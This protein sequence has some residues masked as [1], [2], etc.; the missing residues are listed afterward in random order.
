MEYAE[1]RA[2]NSAILLAAEG[3]PDLVNTGFTQARALVE[4]GEAR[5]TRFSETSELA[6]LNRSG[7]AW[8]YASKE[9]FAVVAESRACFEETNHL[10][11]PTI[12]DALEDAG[13]DRS[14]DDIRAR[15]LVAQPRSTVRF[16][17]DLRAVQFDDTARAIR[18]PV[19]M[20]LD[21]GGIAKGWI[22]EQAARRL[23]DYADACAVDAGGDMYLVGL[24]RGEAVWQVALE[25]PR[26][27]K[28]VLGTLHVGP[29]AVATSSITK[30]R[31]QQGDR[32]RH[33]LIDPRRGEPAET[34]WLSVTVVAPHAAIAE[35]FAKS[36]LIAGSR[37]AA[38]LARVRH[39]IVFIAVD[40]AG[41]LWGS[42]N[43]KELLDVGFEYA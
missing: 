12:L 7:G 23:A 43:A 21:L 17:Q 20:R 35:V 16:S 29:G 22:A 36:L 5:L 14:M 4:A 11:D 19:G 41:K 42:N 24:P 13:Y 18:M 3:A 10:F 40:Q 27:E 30:R 28:A 2:M 9:L 39:D 37:E 15:A 8:F 38:S 25:D 33:H 6:A 32:A 1:F 31:W 26:D 34:D